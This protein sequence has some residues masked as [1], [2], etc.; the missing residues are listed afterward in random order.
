MKQS[1]LIIVTAVFALAGGIFAQYAI[2]PETEIEASAIAEFDLPD[3][4]SNKHKL[5]EWNGK[6]VIL[7]FWA[8]WCPPCRKEIPEFVALQHEYGNKG[9]QFIGIAIEDKEPVEEFIDFVDINYPILIG[10][11]GA[12]ELAQKM[13]N[14][15]GAVPFSVVIDRHGQIVHRQPGEFSKD[16][17]IKTI[18]PLL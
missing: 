3:L 8:T 11:D 4:E 2:D 18:E 10:G 14:R 16:D 7:N 15:F 5:S 9:L 17:V 1:I 13:G 6:I 12:I